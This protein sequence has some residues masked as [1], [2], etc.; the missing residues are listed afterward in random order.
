MTDKQKQA[1]RDMRGH[2]FSYRRIADA[3]GLTYN[4]V[5]SFCYRNN[6][7]CSSQPARFGDNRELCKYCGK[8]LSRTKGAKPKTFCND[9]C[10]YSWWNKNRKYTTKTLFGEGLP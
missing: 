2:E 1:I 7:G 10:R 6:I 5:K 9:K 8:L 3:L 4:T